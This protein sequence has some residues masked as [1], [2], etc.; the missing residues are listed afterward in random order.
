M[1]ALALLLLFFGPVLTA[2][3]AA[4]LWTW[5]RF[6]GEPDAPIYGLAAGAAVGVA[7]FGLLRRR[8]LLREV[9]MLALSVLWA[10][11]LWMALTDR[12]YDWTRA[13]ALH[14]PDGAERFTLL[15]IVL[16]YLTLYVLA[17]ESRPRDSN[18]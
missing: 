16:V 12:R 17:E 3:T 9:T 5:A 7:V 10:G 2:P 11:W 15:L 8:G 6:R 14:A 4:G 18:V 1:R 13:P